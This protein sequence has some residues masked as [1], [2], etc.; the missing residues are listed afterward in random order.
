LNNRGKSLF[1][2]AL[3]YLAWFGA[4]YM[5]GIGHDY[6]AI[7]ILGIFCLGN[8]LVIPSAARNFLVVAL[9]C[10]L[11]D[12]LVYM[13]S[14]TLRYASAT[15]ELVAYPLWI[16]LM[17]IAFVSC[18]PLSLKFL[19]DLKTIQLTVLGAIA[20]PL[21]AYSAS[22]FSALEFPRGTSAGLIMN[23][24]EWGILLP[25]SWYVWRNL[26]RSSRAG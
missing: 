14:G 3:F 4:V 24:F 22:K 5:A 1:Q 25:L 15:F 18:Y 17:W 26:P 19:A 16:V 9:F 10:A 8:F 7:L 6:L 23:A 11:I 21:S 2:G 13:L 20:G 12:L